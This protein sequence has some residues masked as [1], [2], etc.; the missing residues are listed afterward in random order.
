LILYGVR[1]VALAVPLLL[2]MSVLIFGLMRLVPGD[3]AVAVL[4]YKATPE[5]I[6]A[7]R[8]AFHLDDPIPEKYLRWLGAVA[9]GDLG[10]DFRQ[11]EPIGR[12]ILDRLPVTLELTGLAALCTAL[13]GVPLGLLAGGRRGGGTDRAA[14]AVGLIGVSIPDFWLGIMLILGLSLGAGLL[15]S[16]GWVPFAESPVENLVH[17]TLPALTLALSRAAVLGRLTRAAVLDTMHRGFVQYA[18]A[19]GLGERAILFRH[20]LPN[21]AIPIVTVL[22]LQVG[23]MLGGAI[24]VE[25][26]F[27]LPG[28]GRMTL[29]A[30]LERNY[31]VVQSAVLVI[32]AMFMLVNLVTD[33]LYGA[34]DP[35]MRRR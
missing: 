6:A 12:M 10:H 9:R 30:V 13:I 34:I 4:G 15:P 35:R 2:G 1:R 21:A 19:K 32:G 29:D 5:G 3:P 24:V 23:Y 28:L 22:G 7:L 17:L 11:N 20:V 27:T 31:P 14:L 18:R 25:M 33:V 16:G 8:E 26:I